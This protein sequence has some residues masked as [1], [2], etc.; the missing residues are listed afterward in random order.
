MSINDI[1]NQELGTDKGYLA[2][3]D[4]LRKKLPNFHINEEN[5]S[6][7]KVEDMSLEQFMRTGFAGIYQEKENRIGIFTNKDA[8]GEDIFNEDFSPRR[9]INS[10]LHEIIHA[11]TTKKVDDRTTLQGINIRQTTEEGTTDSFLV[12]LNEGITQMITDEVLEEESDAYP[13]LKNFAKQ[14]GCIIGKDKLYEYYS[15]NNIQGLMRHIDS[16]YGERIAQKLV[17]EIYYFELVCEGKLK[18][19]GFFLGDKI[20]EELTELHKRSGKQDDNFDSLV[21]TNEKAKEFISQLP[22]NIGS[23]E[24]IGFRGKNN[25]EGGMKNG[26]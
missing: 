20:Q 11:A 26:I 17:Q 10:T 5:I 2:L 22:R 18:D 16:I 9:L 14:L 24:E 25:S 13:F 6:T 15:T 21:I 19:G 3:V 1:I 8:N 7:L 4:L 23:I 12:Y